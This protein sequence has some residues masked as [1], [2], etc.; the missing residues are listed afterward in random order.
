MHGASESQ[1]SRTGL[2]QALRNLSG[3]SLL[4]WAVVFSMRHLNLILLAIALCF[5]FA[6]LK[7]I[8]WS[9]PALYIR[10]VGS[11]APLILVPYGVSTFLAAIAWRVLLPLNENRPTVW[12]LWLLRLGGE[13]LNQLTPTA[14]LG[15]EPF[16]AI[17]L[18]A[19]GVSWH[20][21][22]AS[23]VIQKGLLVLSLVLYILVA[24]ALVPFVLHDGHPRLGGLLLGVLV[25]G[26]LGV[27]FVVVQR[28]NPCGLL[29]RCMKRFGLTSALARGRE[30]DLETLDALLAGFYH[31]HPGRILAAFS[32]FF[33][34]WT[35]Q[36]AEVFLIFTLMRHP[37]GWG[38]ALCLD[39]LAMLFTGL[40]FMIPASLGVQ[41]GGNLLLALGFR[42]G[43]TLG[44]AFSIIR[45]V[46]EAVWLALGLVVVARER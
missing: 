23:L 31:A 36:S 30:A 26:G 39:G 8:G 6:M 19:D 17:R 40:G 14:S 15:G 43:A 32:L 16:K 22:V 4:K 41:D 34:S 2:C 3:T 28:S 38:V 29:V 42:L 9:N 25:L 12:R 45:R 37:L 10:Q 11:Y 24:I 13:S 7:S 44:V 21:A 46:R 33:L 20:E 1:R 27:A 5:M 35:A 18:Q